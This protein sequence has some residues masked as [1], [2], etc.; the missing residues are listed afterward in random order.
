VLIRALEPVAGVEVMR[1]RRPAARK[2]EELASGPGRLT[3][4]LGITRALNGVDVTRPPL[5]VERWEGAGRFRIAVTPRIG[6]THC[7]DWPLRFVVAGNRFVSGPK[8]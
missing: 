7:A 1:E 4:A 5:R 2:P 3:R 8:V 6:I